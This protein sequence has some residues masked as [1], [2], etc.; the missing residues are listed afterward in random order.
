MYMLANDVDE[1]YLVLKEIFTF[2]FNLDT[3][4]IYS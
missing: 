3:N 2:F 1:Y 4:R